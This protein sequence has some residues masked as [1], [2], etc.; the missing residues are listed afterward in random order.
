MDPPEIEIRL[1][2]KF[3]FGPLERFSFISYIGNP[4][5]IF[6]KHAIFLDEP[7]RAY[8]YTILRLKHA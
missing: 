1:W 5:I 8:F 3:F 4:L 2:Q 7:G 6:Y